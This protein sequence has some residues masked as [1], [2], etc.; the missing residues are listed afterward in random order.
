M[1]FFAY[2]WSFFFSSLLLTESDL[3]GL[4]DTFFDCKYWFDEMM[5]LGE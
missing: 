2:F 4:A 1:L 5:A 3:D